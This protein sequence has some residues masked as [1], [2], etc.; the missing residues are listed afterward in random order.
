MGGVY[1][2]TGSTPDGTYSISA[3]QTTAFEYTMTISGHRR[4]TQ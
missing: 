3:S 1:T 4:R 2:N